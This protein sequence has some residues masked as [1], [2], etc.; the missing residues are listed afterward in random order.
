[1][2]FYLSTTAAQSGHRSMTPSSTPTPVTWTAATLRAT[3]QAFRMSCSWVTATR[4][5]S[6][7][8]VQ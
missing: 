3:T 2:G 1:L 4:P 5:R 6:G 7:W 8:F